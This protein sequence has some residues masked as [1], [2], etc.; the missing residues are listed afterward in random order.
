MTVAELK[1]WLTN[2]SDDWEVRVENQQGD[3]Y[4]AKGGGS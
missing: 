4:Q 2:V 3:T 1:E